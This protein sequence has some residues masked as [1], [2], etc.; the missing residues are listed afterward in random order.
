MLNR[1]LSLLKGFHDGKR[2]AG[3]N[4]YPFGVKQEPEGVQLE[5]ERSLEGT[6]SKVSAKLFPI[7]TANPCRTPSHFRCESFI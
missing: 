5:F 2:E 7:N 6:H 1:Y 4:H 3:S